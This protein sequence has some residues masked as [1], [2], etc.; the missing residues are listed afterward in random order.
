MEKD[1]AEE[2]AAQYEG[3][4]VFSLSRAIHKVKVDVERLNNLLVKVTFNL[5]GQEYMF[6][7]MLS[8]QE[9][10]TLMLI[11][12]RV[13]RD[14]IITGM[15]GFMYQKPNVHGGFVKRLGS[16]YF[17]LTIDS[18]HGESKEVYFMGKESNEVNL[19]MER[20]SFLQASA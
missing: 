4:L 2:L 17:H 20:R 13:S 8:E 1:L 9:E 16:F 15:S 19:R 5:Q 10:G 6:R 18:F 7:A 11:Q 14:Y 3:N 12:D